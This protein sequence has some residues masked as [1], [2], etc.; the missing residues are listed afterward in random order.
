MIIQYF[1]PDG[2]VQSIYE[3]DNDPR[4]V[5]NSLLDYI[6]CP[7]NPDLFNLRHEDPAGEV[8]LSVV[9]GVLLLDGTTYFTFSGY[10]TYYRERLDEMLNAKVNQF[11]LLQLTKVQVLRQMFDNGT[12]ISFPQNFYNLST[13]T[14]IGVSNGAG[15]ASAE[16]YLLQNALTHLNNRL[17][18]YA[19][20]KQQIEAATTISDL[21]SIKF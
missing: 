10:Q 4:R 16:A 21:T 15:L 8:R 20:Y 3:L 18:T 5:S 17:T 11:G 9:D 1:K 14:E 7:Y 13:G 2:K 19:T 12:T 6:H